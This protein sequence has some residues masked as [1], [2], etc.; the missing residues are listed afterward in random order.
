MELTKKIGTVLEGKIR[1]AL[2]RRG[3][4]RERGVGW[5]GRPYQKL[6]A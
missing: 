4:L 5:V 3:G 1:E 6:E 2:S